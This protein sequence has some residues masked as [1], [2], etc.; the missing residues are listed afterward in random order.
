MN[1][2]FKSA[3]L[4]F[5]AFN[6][7]DAEAFYNNHNEEKFKQWFPGN[8]CEDIEEALEE[9]DFFRGCVNDK[10]LPYVLAIEL[11]ETSELIGDTGANEV[12]GKNNEVEIGFSICEKHQGFGYATEAVIAMSKF[13]MQVFPVKKLYGRVLKGN[14]VSCK[15]LQKSGYKYKAIEM[16]AEDD[17]YGN[18]M[19]V[20]VRTKYA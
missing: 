3:R 10:V 18:G 8:E 19:L 5:R 15:I 17:P 1:Y 6:K 11:L 2:I 4:G 14:D 20:Y 9:I 7:N 12:E 13:I 16:E